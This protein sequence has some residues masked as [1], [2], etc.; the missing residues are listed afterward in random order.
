MTATFARE[1]RTWLMQ[2]KQAAKARPSLFHF[3]EYSYA[4]KCL[5]QACINKQSACLIKRTMMRYFHVSL[6]RVSGM[7]MRDLWDK[8]VKDEFCERFIYIKEFG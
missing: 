2:W 1:Y 3:S 5:L 6:F 8:K 7:K 4:G